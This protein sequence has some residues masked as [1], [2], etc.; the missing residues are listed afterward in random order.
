MTGDRLP[1][2]GDVWQTD[3]DPVLG[4]E[5]GGNRPAVVVSIDGVNLG[6]SELA[7]VVPFSSRE[8]G[9]PFHVPVQGGVGG[10]RRQSFALC[11]ME[12]VVS[13]ERLRFYRGQPPD[14]SMV[15]IEDRLRILLGL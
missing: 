10:L 9:L 3:V 7:I 13:R 5:Q 11:E 4:H 6:P 14:E 15:L 2:R 1:K 8:R 12:R